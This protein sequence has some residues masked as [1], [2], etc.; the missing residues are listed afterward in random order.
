MLF[1]KTFV[2]YW[3][4]RKALKTARKSEAIS[5]KIIRAS[6]E[7]EAQYPEGS[8]CQVQGDRSHLEINKCAENTLVFPETYPEF[9]FEE[10]PFYKEVSF[11]EP[12][13]AMRTDEQDSEIRHRPVPDYAMLDAKVH[14]MVEQCKAEEAE[15]T[16]SMRRIPR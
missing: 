4:V 16:P 12:N 6:K 13:V 5:E 10:N 15:P 7:R 11:I 3:A 8:G 14:D 2:E 9:T 1:V